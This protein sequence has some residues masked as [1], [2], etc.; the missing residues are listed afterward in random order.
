MMQHNNHN[1]L[2]SHEMAILLNEQLQLLMES[3]DVN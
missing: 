3:A 1:L 2:F